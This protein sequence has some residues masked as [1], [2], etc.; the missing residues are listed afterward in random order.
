VLFGYKLLQ[1]SINQKELHAVF[2]PVYDAASLVYPH[3]S[4]HGD[5]GCNDSSY[6]DDY[7]YG[8]IDGWLYPFPHT[9]V[10]FR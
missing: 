4:R 9:G 1:I 6:G 5:D 2:Q 10:G 8:T 7:G 3:V